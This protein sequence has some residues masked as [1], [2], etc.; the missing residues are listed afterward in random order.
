VGVILTDWLYTNDFDVEW[1]GVVDVVVVVD[2]DVDDDRK[3]VSLFNWEDD[4]DCV[5]L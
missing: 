4:D 2:V 5:S 3:R 1:D